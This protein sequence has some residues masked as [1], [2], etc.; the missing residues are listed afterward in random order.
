[1]ITAILLVTS[2]FGLIVALMQLVAM[3]IVAA[4]QGAF[5]GL[6]TGLLEARRDSK[7]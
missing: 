4:I 2:V 5:E 6:M 3:C 7:K 1:M